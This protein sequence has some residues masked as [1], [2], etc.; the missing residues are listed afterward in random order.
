MR[1]SIEDLFSWFIL[2]RVRDKAFSTLGHFRQVLSLANQPYGGTRNKDW[3]SLKLIIAS[4]AVTA[5]RSTSAQSETSKYKNE[6]A[7]KER[8]CS[9]VRITMA[10]CRQMRSSYPGIALD[11][12][13]LKYKRCRT[14]AQAQH[15]PA[16]PSYRLQGWSG[17]VI[18]FDVVILL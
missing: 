14:S 4:Y 10:C 11:R 6:T 18:C 7:R 15:I 13:P 5:S 3:R 1:F 9:S 2:I 17:M 12:G 8:E 16:N